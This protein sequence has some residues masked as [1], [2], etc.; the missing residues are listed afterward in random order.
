MK[1]IKRYQDLDENTRNAL[2]LIVYNEFGDV[3]I[4][5]EYEWA[6]PDWAV[7]LYSNDEIAT[8]GH[9]ITRTSFFDDEEMKVGGLNNMITVKKYRGEGFAQEVLKST[10]ELIFKKLKCDVGLLLCADELVPFYQRYG[11]YKVHSTLY[12]DQPT[13]KM[14]WGANVMLLTMNGKLKPKTIDLNGLPW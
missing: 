8:V 14:K 6:T 3:P 7:I 1:L 4:I 13:E 2:S 10:H 12:F 5:N 9:V 11:W